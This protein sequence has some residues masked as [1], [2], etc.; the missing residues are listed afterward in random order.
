[1][2]F[3]KLHNIWNYFWTQLRIWTVLGLQNRYRWNNF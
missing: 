3:E 2:Y 1:M